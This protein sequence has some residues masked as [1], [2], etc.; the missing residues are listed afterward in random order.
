[1]TF[2]RLLGAC[3]APIFLSLPAAAESLPEGYCAVVMASKPSLP[4]VHDWITRN[5]GFPPSNVYRSNN[6]YLA[7]TA[8]IIEID[9]WE[10]RVAE[11]TGQ[12]KVPEG[13]FCS[14]RGLV[15]AVSPFDFLPRLVDVAPTPALPAPAQQAP[16]QPVAKL[17][18]PEPSSPQLAR[19][20][21]TM[22]LTE[23][24][25]EQL[26]AAAVGYVGQCHFEV[27]FSDFMRCYRQANT[28]DGPTGQLNF[29][30]LLDYSMSLEPRVL[31]MGASEQKVQGLSNSCTMDLLQGIGD[32]FFAQLLSI[33]CVFFTLR[34]EGFEG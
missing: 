3:L 12:G 20:S 8:G 28:Y 32:E 21:R 10:A 6:E 34:A 17:D 11:L 19:R 25:K 16:S 23:A 9:G 18:L 15:T 26:D 5:P 30:Q 31:R 4:E 29:V 14:A 13:S 33:A 22:P 2:I 24:E 1:M 7:I 27:E